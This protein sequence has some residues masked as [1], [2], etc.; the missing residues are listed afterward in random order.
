MEYIASNRFLDKMADF[1]KD[2]FCLQDIEFFIDNKMTYLIYENEQY[3]KKIN[4]LDVKVTVNL[5]EYNDINN[6]ITYVFK[7]EYLEGDEENGKFYQFEHHE[8][9]SKMS[10]S[11]YEC[12]KNDIK[13]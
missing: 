3:E 12:Y 7:Y 4:G 10:C 1:I 8:Y 6:Q 9:C 5:I 11:Y 2:E 13:N